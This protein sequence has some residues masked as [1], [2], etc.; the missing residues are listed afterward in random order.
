ME[1]GPDKMKLN[2]NS[3][4]LADFSRAYKNYLFSFEVVQP[5]LSNSGELLS[6]EIISRGYVHKW[7]KK[8][9]KLIPLVKITD[10]LFAANMVTDSDFQEIVN[11]ATV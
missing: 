3:L 9:L 1:T 11:N 8:D 10:N 5:K 7:R 6:I 4:Y 2:P